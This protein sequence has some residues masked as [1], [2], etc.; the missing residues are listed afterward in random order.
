MDILVYCTR[1]YEAEIID[2][3]THL[4]TAAQ[5]PIDGFNRIQHMHHIGSGWM[6]V[7]FLAKMHRLV[8]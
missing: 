5:P 2:Q 6:I 1:I 3:H 8:Q 4:N 7:P